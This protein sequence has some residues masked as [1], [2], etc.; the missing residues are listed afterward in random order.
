MENKAVESLVELKIRRMSDK[1]VLLCHNMLSGC[2]QM[3]LGP[4]ICLLPLKR[5][6]V[7]LCGKSLM[8]HF[9][10]IGSVVVLVIK[11]WVKL[12]I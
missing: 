5:H 9:M 6:P 8:K 1:A 7:V 11:L 12:R 4:F 2:A 3:R 10:S